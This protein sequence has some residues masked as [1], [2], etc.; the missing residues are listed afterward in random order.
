MIN[1]EISFLTKPHIMKPLSR[2]FSNLHQ[3]L[4]W[5]VISYTAVCITFTPLYE[6]I[7]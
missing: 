6:M 1:D 7:R 2:G 4:Y 3:V 5:K